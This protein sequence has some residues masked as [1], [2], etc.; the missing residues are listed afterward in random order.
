MEGELDIPKKARR[1][2]PA[3]ASP[4]SVHVA[5]VSSPISVH[6]ASSVV[7]PHADIE[8]A[9]ACWSCFFVCLLAATFFLQ[10]DC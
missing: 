2:R 6:I 9:T 7:A 8:G 5:S 3:V 1:F 4:T 10:Q